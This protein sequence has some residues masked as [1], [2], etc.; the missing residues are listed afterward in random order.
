MTKALAHSVQDAV[1]F[2]SRVSKEVPKA[3]VVLGSGV[4]VLEDLADNTFTYDQI[5]GMSP[6]IVG[7]AG[8]LSLGRVD[9]QLVAVL[10]GRFHLYEGHNWDVVT[11]P[12]KVLAAWGVPYLF[13]TNAAG[14]INPKF[15]VGDLML[16]KGYRDHLNPEWKE[17]GLVPA[18]M[19]PPTDCQNDLTRDLWKTG[20][21]LASQEPSFRPLRT[22][23]YAALLGPTYE[24]MAEIEM[25]RRLGADAVG[26]STVPELDTVIG[27]DTKA[28][29]I[30]VVTNVWSA[31]SA[32]EGHEEVLREAKA[33]SER[34][35]KL[36]RATIAGLN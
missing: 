19:L 7:H 27:T 22:G 21:Q 25:L 17:S 15:Q 30:S 34:L 18:L 26:M 4:K 20:E 35:D 36:F 14:G 12:A 3:A 1:E 23:V 28:V 2:L 24:T 29:A 10:R 32:I 13:L 11:L 9:G 16:L 31:D 8:S 5:F 6:T 33:A